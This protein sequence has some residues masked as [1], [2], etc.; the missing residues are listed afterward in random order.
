M[1]TVIDPGEGCMA[2]APLHFIGKVVIFMFRTD[3]KKANDVLA[4]LF[5]RDPSWHPSFSKCL[6]PPQ[7]YGSWRFESV[8]VFVNYMYFAN[9]LLLIKIKFYT[10]EVFTSCYF[11]YIQF[12]CVWFDRRN[13]TSVHKMQVMSTCM[14]INNYKKVFRIENKYNC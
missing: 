5:L 2:L 12:M 10:C 13:L 8:L 3:K 6:D 4:P 1:I 7:W 11:T 14:F 9:I